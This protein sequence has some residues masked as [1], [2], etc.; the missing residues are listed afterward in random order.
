MNDRDNFKL[1][2]C[3]SKVYQFIRDYQ[4]NNNGRVPSQEE[5]AA[6]LDR[7]RSTV[8]FHLDRLIDKGYITHPT[9]A[10]GR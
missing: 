1:S 7:S 4:I 5:I 6:G 9:A 2:T 3:Q 8:R 10:K